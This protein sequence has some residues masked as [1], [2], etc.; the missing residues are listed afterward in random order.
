VID[1]NSL[2]GMLMK[3]GVS[4][5]EESLKDLLWFRD[6]LLRWNRSINLTAITEPAEAL[7]KHLVDSLT[8]KPFI[9]GGSTL[10]DIGS[11][12]GFPA[13]PLKIADPSLTV[14]SVDASGKKI[15]FQKHV[16]R[17][18]SLNRFNALHLRAEEL[19]HYQ[20]LPLF[21]FVVARAFSSIGTILRLSLPLLKEGGQVVAMKGAEASRELVDAG[22]DIAMNHMV[23]CHRH[24]LQLPSSGAIRS[25]LFFTKRTD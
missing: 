10:L 17:T 2:A 7:E 20:N 1:S 13:L 18:L 16:A 12:G 25:L 23:C 4:V 8:L 6:E 14:W 11:G 9:P 19:P 22:P 24:H 5:P 21:D 15:A 3:M